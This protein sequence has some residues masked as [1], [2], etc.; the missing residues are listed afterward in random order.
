MQML[1]VEVRQP[2]MS[3]GHVCFLCFQKDEGL[4]LSTVIMQPFLTGL[5]Q[6]EHRISFHLGIFY[7]SS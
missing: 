1:V 3:T 6:R 4:G 7:P 5:I 2:G